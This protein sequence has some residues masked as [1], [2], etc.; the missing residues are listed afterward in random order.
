VEDSTRQALLWL[1]SQ[2]F[3]VIVS[4]VDWRSKA[5]KQDGSSAIEEWDTWVDLL[6]V[7]GTEPLEGYGAGKTIEEAIVSAAERLRIEG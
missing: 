6:H 5:R 1:R 7:N 3:R 4:P 2:K